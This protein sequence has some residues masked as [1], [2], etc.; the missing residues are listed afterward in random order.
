L[1]WTDDDEV[2]SEIAS[3]RG[4]GVQEIR[5]LKRKQPEF[6]RAVPY[7]KVRSNWSPE[8]IDKAFDQMHKEL[9]RNPS[10]E[11]FAAKFKG[12]MN[13]IQDGRYKLQIRKWSQYLTHRGFVMPERKDSRQVSFEEKV[14]LVET[15]LFVTKGIL[16]LC[17][18]IGVSYSNVSERYSNDPELLR[19]VAIKRGI[20]YDEVVGRKNEKIRNKIPKPFRQISFEAKVA[21]IDAYLFDDKNS[22]ELAE[23][24]V[25]SPSSVFNWYNKDQVLMEVARR[26]SLDYA[27]VV[28]LRDKRRKS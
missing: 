19:G 20:S 23:L 13:A 4:L 25:I 15:Y 8:N 16:N 1:R 14:L 6:Q 28:N 18:Q 2:L 11:E 27:E 5:E 26:R 10:Y 24:H 3:R 12:A 7:P 22:I 17:R 9:G 21:V